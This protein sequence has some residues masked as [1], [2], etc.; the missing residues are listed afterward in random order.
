MHNIIELNVIIMRQLH[1]K[2]ILWK[3]YDLLTCYVIEHFVCSHQQNSL[4]RNVLFMTVCFAYILFF[5]CVKNVW[6]SSRISK[7]TLEK[8]VIRLGGAEIHS[9]T[10]FN[11]LFVVFVYLKD[12]FFARFTHLLKS[13]II[14]YLWNNTEYNELFIHIRKYVANGLILNLNIYWLIFKLIH[15]L[16]CDFKS[17]LN[18]F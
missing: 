6:W 8:S 13:W 5:L 16:K 7:C 10:N 3:S 18:K 14:N 11:I 12:L 4:Y 1:Q 17:W 15:K 2:Y 9:C